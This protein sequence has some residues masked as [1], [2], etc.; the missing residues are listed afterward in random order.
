MTTKPS[1]CSYSMDL[2]I[3]KWES[4]CTKS[5]KCTHRFSDRCIQNLK[6]VYIFLSMYTKVGVYNEDLGAENEKK[7]VFRCIT[8]NTTKVI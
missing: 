7:Q 1:I 5:I 8:V 6:N 4:M 2:C 3:Q